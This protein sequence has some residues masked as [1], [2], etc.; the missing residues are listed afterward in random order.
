M[1]TTSPKEKVSF[2][3]DSSV[4]LNPAALG[5]PTHQ[6][7]SNRL[8]SSSLSSQSASN[9]NLTSQSGELDVV[10]NTSSVDVIEYDFVNSTTK[11]GNSS[12]FSLVE[13]FDPLCEKAPP[14]KEKSKKDKRKSSSSSSSLASSKHGGE[15]GSSQSPPTIKIEAAVTLDDKPD[16]FCS[17]SGQ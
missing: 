12:F 17:L 14:S 4:L 16:L 8:S 15:S 2:S 10:N 9:N 5:Q 6:L 3:I 11:V 7:D 13:E 1:D